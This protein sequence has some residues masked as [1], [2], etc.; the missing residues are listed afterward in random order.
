MA[1]DIGKEFW[2]SKLTGGICPGGV[3]QKGYGTIGEFISAIL[4]NVFVIAG[5]ILFFLIFLGG[6]GLLMAGG[7]SEKLSKA[8]GT[9]TAAVAGFAIIFAS[10]WLIQIIENLTGVKIFGL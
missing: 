8:K 4:P 1:V 2:L 6:F 9:I 3:C 5:L 7:D 10:Y